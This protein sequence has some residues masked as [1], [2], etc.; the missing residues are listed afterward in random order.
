MR[1]TVVVCF[2]CLAVALARAG[3]DW[4]QW[5]G[6]T[7]DG[8]S[9]CT[10]LPTE[11]GEDRNVVWKVPLP[12]WSGATPIVSGDRVFVMSPSKAEA[13]ETDGDQHRGGQ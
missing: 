11:W 8:V 4:P 13:E 7:L 2:I 12:S 10:N 1:L 9:A 3:D 5:R 6:P